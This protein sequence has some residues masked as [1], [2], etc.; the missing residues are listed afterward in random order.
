MKRPVGKHQ[1]T[2][3]LYKYIDYLEDKMDTQELVNPEEFLVDHQIPVS[4]MVDRGDG[5]WV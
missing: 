4:T 5:K 1:T 3:H 2:E